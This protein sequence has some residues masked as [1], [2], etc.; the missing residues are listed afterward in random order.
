MR[1]EKYYVDKISKEIKEK[2]HTDLK[3]QVEDKKRQIHEFFQN[4]RQLNKLPKNIMD[5]ELLRDGVSQEVQNYL[6]SIKGN[7]FGA[8]SLPT[9]TKSKSSDVKKAKAK[10]SVNPKKEKK[11]T[12]N[13]KVDRQLADDGHNQI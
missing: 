6:L 7:H 4:A 10:S 13:P 12:K 11:K 2:D 8:P 9:K 3:K 5:L 1:N